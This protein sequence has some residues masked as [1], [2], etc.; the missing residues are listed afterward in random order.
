ML[1]PRFINVVC[2][3]LPS[4]SKYILGSHSQLA[5]MLAP[6]PPPLMF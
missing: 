4:L 1:S 3:F 2:V 5:S 6:A